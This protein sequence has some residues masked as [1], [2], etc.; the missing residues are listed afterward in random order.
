MG[1]IIKQ[2][3]TIDE[4]IVLLEEIIK[5]SV[6]EESPL[7][8]FASL[9]RKVTIKIKDGVANGV[10]Q[11]GSR[12]EKLDVVFANRYLKAYYQ[13]MAGQNPSVCWKFAFVKGGEYW[14]IVLQHLLLGINAHINL[15]LGVAAAQVCP[16][17]AIHDL[18]TDFDKINEILSE[19]VDDV[20]NA[21]SE[22][23]PRLKT[24]LKYTSGADTFLIDFS[25]QTAREGAW[26]FAVEL[27]SLT[28]V[29]SETMIFGRDESV[30]KIAALVS[31]PG[32][33]ASSAFKFI[34]IFER[35]TVAEK[36]AVLEKIT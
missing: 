10:F 17:N 23:W 3:A 11:D 22:V 24:I 25:M 31:N 6:N 12:M 21:L 34:R 32:F 29:Q 33:V 28:T 18:K 2:A 15:D 9:Y 19:L 1:V 27:A 8:Y 30:R 7:G 36:I 26:K 35:G 4:V 5:A 20:E 14:P 13:Y 16:G